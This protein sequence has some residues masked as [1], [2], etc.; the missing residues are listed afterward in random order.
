MRL[1]KGTHCGFLMSNIIALYSEPRSGS[2]HLIR[3]LSSLSLVKSLGEI[4]LNKSIND[5]PAKYLEAEAK[6]KNCFYISKIFGWQLNK[7]NVN[8][9]QND[10]K[11]LNLLN[12]FIYNVHL[13]RNPVDS[14]ISLEKAQ[15]YN[16]WENVDTSEIQIR[17]DLDK[18]KKHEQAS[19]DWND[20]VM[21]YKNLNAKKF[22]NF[23]YEKEDWSQPKLIA[24][25]FCRTFSDGNF[26]KFE[27]WQDYLSKQDNAELYE[28]KIINY[29]EVS[30][31][32][33]EGL[34]RYKEYLRISYGDKTA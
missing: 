15:V 27:A 12:S 3:I 25:K 10:Q 21:K 22:I 19:Y 2:S 6:D 11:W 9:S 34:L 7:N 32:I 16:R 4:F 29:R 28:R 23:I 8:W 1:L 17:F 30:N 13:V 14:F 5:C 31:V 24:E 18:F 26:G 33:N 20:A